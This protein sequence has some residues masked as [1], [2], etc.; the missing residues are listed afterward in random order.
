[1]GMIQG[2]SGLG[3]GQKPLAENWIAGH[4]GGEELDGGLAL[5]AGVF[6]EEDFAHA[7]SAEPGGDAIVP[8]RLTDHGC[9]P[10]VVQP[11]SPGNRDGFGNT[12]YSLLCGAYS[13]IE[14][15]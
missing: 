1:M 5:Q 14:I 13:T 9:A 8:D 2:R 7:A 3:F 11:M 10:R 15:R 4:R 12:P 6:G